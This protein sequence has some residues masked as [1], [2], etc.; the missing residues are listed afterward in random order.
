MSVVPTAKRPSTASRLFQ[1][2]CLAYGL[3]VAY[4]S[5]RKRRFDALEAAGH[6]VPVEAFEPLALPAAAPAAVAIPEPEPEIVEEPEIVTALAVEPEPD[7]VEAPAP[8]PAREPDPEPVAWPQPRPRLALVPEQPAPAAAEEPEQPA[9]SDAIAFQPIDESRAGLPDGLRDSLWARAAIRVLQAVCIAYSAALLYVVWLAKDITIASLARDPVFGGYSFLV[10]LYVLARFSLAPLYR[11][12]PDTGHRPSCSI[13]IPA[14]NEEGCIEATIDACFSADYPADLI[15]VVVV[16]DGS[17]DRTW[18]RML[19]ARERHPSL[20]CVQFSQN[21]GKRAAMA[22][23]IRRSSGEICVFID[24]D[25]VIE[26][27]GLA[28]IMAD[29]RDEKVGA[30]VGTADVMNKAQNRMTKMQQVRYFVAFRVVKGSESVFGAVTCASGCFS[31]YRRSALLAILPKWEGQRFL[32]RPAT[33]GDDRALTNYILRDHKVTYQSL[34]RSHTLAPDTLKAFLIQQIR[35]RKSWLRESLHVV[36]FMWR[37]HPIAAILTYLGVFFPWVAPVVAFRSLYW[38]SF[39]TG[40][41]WF[42]LMGAYVMALLYSLYY[43]VS[44]KS[45]LW[46][47][48]ITFIVIYMAFLV[49]LTYYALLT[50]RDTGWGTRAS[51][52]SVGEFQVT[53]VGGPDTVAIP[54]AA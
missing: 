8:H 19:A 50:L 23:G 12:T 28:H 41:P 54:E 35:W 14:F 32:G 24:S 42:Y 33:Y 13:V 15:E 20:L 3:A 45:P 17:G 53:V 10:T 2:G 36:R 1:V 21:R 11:P 6:D 4:D 48:G 34:A 49:W 52:H 51:T 30:V 26:P 18:E 27:D 22:E 25:S 46:H 31:A 40:S 37:K 39:M 38:H 44:R 29:F 43:A 16:D 9:P 7:V 47:H 5:A